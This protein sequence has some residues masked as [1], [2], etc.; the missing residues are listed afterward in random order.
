MGPHVLLGAVPVQSGLFMNW[1]Q[2]VLTMTS[3]ST[4]PSASACAPASFKA[5][6]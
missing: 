6:T 1:V 2:N 5:E 4:P 3:L